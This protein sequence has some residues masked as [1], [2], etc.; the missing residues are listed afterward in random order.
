MEISEVNWKMCRI[1]NSTIVLS[2]PLFP[3]AIENKLFIINYTL[4]KSTTIQHTDFKS[5]SGLM[6]DS[7][8]SLS[9]ISLEIHIFIF[10]IESASCSVIFLIFR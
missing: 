4:D 3:M 10:P 5:L 6:S 7:N 2:Y 8:K 1:L 9:I